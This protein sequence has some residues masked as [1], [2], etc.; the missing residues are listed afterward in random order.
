MAISKSIPTISIIIIMRITCKLIIAS[1]C[2]KE[3]AKC[4]R[5]KERNF[6]LPYEKR[7]MESGEA[8]AHVKIHIEEHS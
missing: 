7:E 2:P 3:R 8:H 1:L 4:E 5:K 6:I